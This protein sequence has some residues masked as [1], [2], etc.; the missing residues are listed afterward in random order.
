VLVAVFAFVFL[1][2]RPS[3]RDWI[4][5]LMVGAGVLILGLKR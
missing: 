1:G 3:A 4:G 5:I 2:E